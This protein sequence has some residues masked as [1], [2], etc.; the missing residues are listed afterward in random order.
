ML[1]RFCLSEKE[2]F[3]T[4]LNAE[5]QSIN[6]LYLHHWFNSLFL[7]AGAK[8]NQYYHLFQIF[9]A[10]FLNY[11]QTVWTG[12]FRSDTYKKEDFTD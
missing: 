12:Y 8:I 10:I 4:I 11:F 6:H 7:I 1:F 3:R 5:Y 2:L 9:Y